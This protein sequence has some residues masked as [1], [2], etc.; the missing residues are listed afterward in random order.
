MG[1]RLGSMQG[2]VRCFYCGSVMDQFLV[3][4]LTLNVK[5]KV[6]SRLPSWKNL[7]RLRDC[8]VTQDEGN[9]DDNGVDAFLDSRA[10]KD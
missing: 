7:K 1:F 8:S 10:Q 5:H 6:N 4:L 3:S 9:E 2:N